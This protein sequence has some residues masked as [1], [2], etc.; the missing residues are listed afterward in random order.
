MDVLLS[1]KAQKLIS[2]AP[3][4]VETDMTEE[5]KAAITEGRKEYAAN[6]QSFKPFTAMR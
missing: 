3:P 4:V 6:P 5:E 1:D 2:D